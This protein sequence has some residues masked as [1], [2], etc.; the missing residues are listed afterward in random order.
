MSLLE[1][2]ILYFCP[3]TPALNPFWTSDFLVS[4]EYLHKATMVQSLVP[5]KVAM[6]EPMQLYLSTAEYLNIRDGH[7]TKK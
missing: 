7:E 6:V 3:Y 4:T 1:H 2:D 5:I